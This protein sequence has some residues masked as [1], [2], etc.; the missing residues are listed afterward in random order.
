MQPIDSTDLAAARPTS[1]AC[2]PMFGAMTMRIGG[3]RENCCAAGRR[4]RAEHVLQ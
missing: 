4:R 2:S 3:A 1:C